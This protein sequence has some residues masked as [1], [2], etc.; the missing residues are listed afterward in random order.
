LYREVGGAKTIR[1]LFEVGKAAEHL[2][3]GETTYALADGAPAR[4][5][6]AVKKTITGFKSR[7]LPKNW[8]YAQRHAP[9][10]SC[11]FSGRKEIREAVDRA[12]D[13]GEGVTYDY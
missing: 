13:H 6:D 4:R 10:G 12:N 3:V 11:I 8:P 7:C 1:R 9:D 2:E 5:P